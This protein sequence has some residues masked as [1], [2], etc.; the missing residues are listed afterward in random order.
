MT[1]KEVASMIASC[2]VDYAY[3]HFTDT[4]HELPFICFMFSGSGDF[5]ADNTNYQKIRPLDIELYTE[6][7]DFTLEQTVEDVLNTYGFVYTREET[8]IEAEQMYEVIFHTSVAVTEEAA[9]EAANT[10][11]GE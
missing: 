8:Y 2:N 5:S 11:E 10:Q 7:K 4:E 6:N 1:Y 3:D 9:V